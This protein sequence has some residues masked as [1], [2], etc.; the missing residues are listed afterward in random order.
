VLGDS[1]TGGGYSVRLYFHPFVRFI[2]IGAVI[3]FLGG[4]VSLTDRRL[5][6]GAPSAA[7]RKPN[8]VPAE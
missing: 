4:A 7:R 3:M 2:W 1:Q 6:I 5:R 8:A